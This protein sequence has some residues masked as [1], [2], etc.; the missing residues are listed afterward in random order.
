LSWSQVYKQQAAPVEQVFA[1]A[2]LLLDFEITAGI[3]ET[4]PH[5]LEALQPH[6]PPALGGTRGVAQQAAVHV[7]AQQQKPEQKVAWA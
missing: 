2:G 5:L 1:D 3:P 4:L 6:I 7:A